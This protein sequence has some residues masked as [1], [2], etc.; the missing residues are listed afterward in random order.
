MDTKRLKVKTEKEGTMKNKKRIL[1][2][3]GLMG[4]VLAC[5]LSLVSLSAAQNKPFL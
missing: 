2:A 3:L 5:V 1:K 4:F